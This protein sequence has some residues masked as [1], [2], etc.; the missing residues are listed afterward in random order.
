M[1]I[2]WP[3]T[4]RQTRAKRP[5]TN[6]VLRDARRLGIE[7]LESRLLLSIT[8][9]S[10][11]G[12]DVFYNNSFYDGNNPAINAADDEAIATNKQALLPGQ[13]ATFANYTSYSK[14]INGVMVDVAN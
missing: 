7:T 5:S 13:T 6:A 8:S 3:K 12:R 10:V 1:L 4:R 9:A 14:G 11:V 2:I